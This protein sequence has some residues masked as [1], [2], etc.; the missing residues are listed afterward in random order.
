MGVEYY[1]SL[2][3]SDFNADENG[4]D[5][6]TDSFIDDG[7]AHSF[8]SRVRPK[9]VENGGDRYRKFYIKAV[10][11]IID[12]GVSISTPSICATEEVLFFKAQS[13]DELESDIDKDNIRFYGGFEITGI[14]GKKITADRDVSLFIKVDDFV[15]FFYR[16]SKEKIYTAKVAEVDV[17]E[18]TFSS[19]GSKDISTGYFCGSTIEIN[20]MNTDDN[21]G[22]WIKQTIDE[23]TE[24]MEEP[25]DSFCVTTHY[26]EQ[27]E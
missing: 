27:D 13:N 14:D 8:I 20:S 4:G 12:I 10:S 5:I 21:H 3:N 6:D 15:T 1:K 26:D 17:D 23:W 11:S 9:L 18:V 25:L 7:V 2:K 22:F 24:P 16:G 19:L